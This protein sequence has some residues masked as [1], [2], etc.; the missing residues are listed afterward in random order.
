MEDDTSSDSSAP[1]K[2]YP[3]TDP[4]YLH[5]GENPA[6]L[7]VP[8]R[9]DGTNYDDWSKSMLTSLGSKN[10]I[11][12]IDGS[13]PMPL[14]TNPL[15]QPWVAC[16]T[17]V[18][19][20]LRLSVTDTI[21]RSLLNYKTAAEVWKNLKKRFSQ[22]DLIRISELQEELSNLKQGTR[23]VSEYYTHLITVWNELIGYQPIPDCDCGGSIHNDCKVS[24]KMAEYQETNYIVQFLRGLNDNYSLAR[25]QILMSDP[26]PDLDSVCYRVTQLERQ[27]IG[28]AGQQKTQPAMAMSAA[29]SSQY[30]PPQPRFPHGGTPRGILPRPSQRGPRPQGTYSSRSH[31]HCTYCKFTGHTYE[32]CWKRI[33]YP[34]GYTPRYSQTPT[35]RPQ[36]AAASSHQPGLI[37]RLSGLNLTQEQCAQLQALIQHNTTTRPNMPNPPTPAPSHTAFLSSVTHPTGKLHPHTHNWILDTGATD[38]MIC[39]IAYF[40]SFHPILNTYITLPNNIRVLATHIGVVNISKSIILHDVLF[41]PSFTFNL[42]S[43]HKLTSTMSI[44]VL[45]SGKM[46][47]LQDLATGR[48]IGSASSSNGLYCLTPSSLSTICIPHHTA[49]TS[50]SQPPSDFDLWHYRLGH[51]SHSKVL[52][53][54]SLDSGIVTKP[55]KPCAICHF[56]KQRKLPFSLSKSVSNAIFDLI[57]IDTWGPNASPSYDG[58]SYFLTIVDDYSRVTW[59]ML[60]KQKSEAKDHI[61]SFCAYAVKQF[62]KSVKRIRSDNAREFLL[63]DFFQAEGIVHET[64]CVETPQQN[65]RVERKHQHIL[66][67]ARALKFQAGLPLCFWSDCIR[68]A[69]FL[70][71]RL[72]SPVLQNQT[73]YQLLHN[74]PPDFSFLRVFG[75]LV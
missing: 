75:S 50:A 55:S 17:T 46:C 42:I 58:Y 5:G 11:P 66:S 35:P 68:H 43:V 20:W 21:R 12:F 44:S 4:Y 45:F 10:K 8:E 48:R 30:R 52:C 31:L 9:L 72:P 40:S 29:Q 27:L 74:K 54:Q 39:D 32:E 18:L 65:S 23:T 51:L 73:P 3:L 57:H 63:T 37:D 28:T 69:V 1:A 16:N 61:K 41:V 59:V 15:Y 71:N 26:L 34:P 62:G 24:L 2:T 49:F 53:L 36:V 38:H 22:G 56:A 60:M 6:L 33:G 13:L 64:S 67:V 7:L 25:T 47:Y 70:I 14:A 19:G